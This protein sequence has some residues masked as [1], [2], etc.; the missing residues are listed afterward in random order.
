[1]YVRTEVCVH[2]Y[3]VIHIGKFICVSVFIHPYAYK[4]FYSLLKAGNMS[5]VKEC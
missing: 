1:M 3:M 5:L 2:L 4:S